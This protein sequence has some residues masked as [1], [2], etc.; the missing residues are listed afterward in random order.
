MSATVSTSP[1]KKSEDPY[2]RKRTASLHRY[3]GNHRQNPQQ[4]QD[5]EDQW[6]WLGTGKDNP[7]INDA[8]GKE[9]QRGVNLYRGILRKGFL[10]PCNTP[11]PTRKPKGREWRLVP[12]LQAI[13]ESNYPSLSVVPDPHIL[14]SNPPLKAA[15]LSMP[16]LCSAFCSNPDESNSQDLFA[17]MWECQPCTCIVMPQGYT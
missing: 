1:M 11:V 10:T 17:I 16:G 2:K 15:C 12:E 4:T 8:L 3:P 13:N 5:K 9:A 6:P 14:L 7:N